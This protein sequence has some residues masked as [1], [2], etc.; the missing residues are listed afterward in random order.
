[1]ATRLEHQAGADPVVFGEEMLAALE[2][3]GAGQLRHA[4]AAHHPH[5]VAAGVAVDAEERVP[6]HRSIFRKSGYRFSAENA[7]N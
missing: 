7:T 5:R 1:V 6:G 2:H 3:A 4:A